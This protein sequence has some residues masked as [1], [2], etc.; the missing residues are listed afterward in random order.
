MYASQSR[1]S[2]ENRRINM[3]I[4]N[5]LFKRIMDILFSIFGLLFFSLPLITAIFLIWKH[6]F[7]SPFYVST[8]VGKDEK[9][10]KIIKLRTMIV[11]A[12]KKGV[13]STAINDSRITPVGHFI[14]R[15]KLDEITQLWNVLKGD[16][17]LVGPRPNVKSETDIYTS[18]EKKLLSV[19]PGI[20]DFASIVFSDEGEILAGKASPDIAYNQLIR[21][22]KSSLGLFYI[23]NKSIYIDVIILVVTILSIISRSTALKI[24]ALILKKLKAPAELI[25]TAK[26]KKK[27]FPKPPPG[28]NKIV[29]SRKL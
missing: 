5:A 2:T 24:N 20:T 21:P 15:Y 16:M 1:I 7:K 8:R 25:T 3:S 13:D 23:K 12:H 26:R 29:T 22:G 6:D 27:L 28:S 17:S 4:L 11:N 18:A 14:R 10:F 19:K 9:P